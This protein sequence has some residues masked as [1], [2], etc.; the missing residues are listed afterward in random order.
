MVWRGTPPLALGDQWACGS[1][2]GA[3]T[4]RWRGRV[5]LLSRGDYTFV[6]KAL[7]VQAAGGVGRPSR[8]GLHC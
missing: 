2:S 1:L 5:V 7:I 8:A 4:S 6:E 3:D